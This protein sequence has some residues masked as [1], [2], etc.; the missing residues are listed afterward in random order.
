MRTR[1]ITFATV[2]AA[3]VALFPSSASAETAVKRD[4]RN[5]AP[6]GIDITRVLYAYSDQRVAAT[7]RVPEL[8]ATGR[9]GLSISRF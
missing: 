8:A 3:V 2:L 6:A 1:T 5:D 7:V 4:D 9:M